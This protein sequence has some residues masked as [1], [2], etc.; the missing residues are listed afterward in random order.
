MTAIIACSL[1]TAALAERKVATSPTVT[2][3]E[4]DSA[5]ISLRLATEGM[6]L[7]ENKNAALP[8]ARSGKVALFGAGAIQTI[9]G[10]TGSGAVNNRIVYADG[11]AVKGVAI[12][13]SVLDG[14]KNSGY[15]VI[16]EDY[17]RAY[18]KANPTS[19]ADMGRQTLAPEQQLTA[20]DVAMYKGATDTA[21]YVVRRSSGE[22]ADRTPTKGDYYLSDAELSNIKLL[23]EAFDKC[24]VVLNVISIDMSWYAASGADAVLLMGQ[25]GELGGDAL[26]QV[27]SGKV[28]PSGKLVDTWAKDYSDYPSSKYFAAINPEDPYSSFI[29]F[30]NEGIYVGYRYFDTFAPEKVAYPFGYG[31]SYTTFSIKTSSVEVDKKL[32]TA[33]VAVKNTGKTAGKEVVQLYF[34]APAG[35]LDKPYQELAAYGKTD[36]LQP[37]ESQTLTI[38]FNTAD[39]S[40]YSEARA[41]YIMEAGPYVIRVGNSSRN[42]T[43]AAVITLDKTV[44]VEQLTNQMAVDR[45]GTT[46]GGSAGGRG[47]PPYANKYKDVTVASNVASYNQLVKAFQSAGASGTRYNDGKSAGAAVKLSLAA[48]DIENAKSVYPPLAKGETYEDVKTYV[49]AT[50]EN[51]DVKGFNYGNGKA[52]NVKP[53][54]FDANGKAVD[55]KPAAM[56]NFR[57][58]SGSEA[59]GTATYY[60]LLDVYNGVLSMEQFVSGMTIEEMANFVEGGNKSPN[61]DGQSAGGTSPS[62]QTLSKSA[63]KKIDDLF[64]RGEAGETC[65]LYIEDRLIPNTTNSDGPAG[66]RVS[67]SYDADGSTYYQFC[68]AYPVGTLIAQ[69]WD[70]G[71][72]YD[73]GSAI[74][75]EMVQNGVTLWLAPGMNIHRN[76]LC[77]RNFE[78][79]SED[80]VIAGT[81]ACAE[82]SGVQSNPGIGVTYKHFAGNNQETTRNASSNVVSERALREIYLKGFEIAVKGSKPMAIM[83][84]YNINNSV[85]AANDYDML[86]NILRKEWG[87]DGM[88]MTDWGGSGGYSDAR[89]MH[90]GN[91]IIMAGKTVAN[92][93]GY[94]A[95][96]AP[97]INYNKDGVATD[98]GY[99][100]VAK[101]TRAS[102]TTVTYTTVTH[103][104]DYEPDPKG[105]S[106]AVA[107]TS[108]AFAA[109]TRP[110][111][112]YVDKQGV[113]Y[114]IAPPAETPTTQEL[115]QWSVKE[116]LDGKTDSAGNLMPGMVKSGTAS[117]VEADGKVT[118]TYKL[119]KLS[120]RDNVSS[121]HQ[122]ASTVDIFGDPDENTLTLGDLQKS[123][124]RI[125]N[126]V[127]ASSQF[128]DL[129]GVASVSYTKARANQLKEAEIVTKSKI[130]K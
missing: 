104:G 26:V 54:Y 96:M 19:A 115:Q 20:A 78:Y 41:A 118:I 34:S 11:K 80:P 35:T 2:Q 103:W 93:I 107:T 5:Q 3:H 92:I 72:A 6:A 110:V 112:I 76:P 60:T 4:I 29:E 62:T 111:R 65:G 18:D 86:E 85:P 119:S 14:F 39:M 63:A 90:A 45:A 7:L 1:S 129:T 36:L 84:S 68:T 42:T 13:S 23:S 28:C 74:G 91:D 94:I 52:Y 105:K 116:L 123:T 114:L 130:T 64:V 89:A 46:P 113:G 37:G 88:V 9:K 30:Y 71:I 70:T 48:K 106:F 79:Y 21:I 56:K 67:Q 57:V 15:E 124:I 75:A 122:A 69:S 49:S 40:S 51:A 24:V 55:T 117:Y 109:S 22:G 99:P 61:A 83:T 98:G 12:A 53:V 81:M 82:G 100:Y 125:L 31:L 102:G 25:A 58:K 32:V 126:M 120:A 33:K 128:A 73:M 44:V 121:G 10:G 43:P 95:D 87:F 66:L 77:G 50:T 59:N 38:S 47:T 16:T 17:L 8:I 101:T 27:L 108:E 97:A 127:M